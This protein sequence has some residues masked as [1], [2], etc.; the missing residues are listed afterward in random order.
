MLT[1]EDLSEQIFYYQLIIKIYNKLYLDM[2]NSK[3]YLPVKI[4]ALD[5]SLL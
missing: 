3:F 1:Q 5:L 2:L 4:K